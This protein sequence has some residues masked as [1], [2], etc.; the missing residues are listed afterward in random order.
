[1][2]IVKMVSPK[3]HINLYYRSAEEMKADLRNMA[4][5]ADV[6][7]GTDYNL[8]EVD[9]SKLNETQSCQ[10]CGKQNVKKYHNILSVAK[11]EVNRGCEACADK[12]M[13]QDN[14]YKL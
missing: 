5:N 3:S 14:G 11:S 8:V 6:K 10:S 13:D 9:E 1:M 7:E 12:V 2:K 4:E